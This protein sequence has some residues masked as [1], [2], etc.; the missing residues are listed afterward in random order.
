MPSDFGP[1]KL[2]LTKG[3]IRV[4]TRG[5]LTALSWKDRRDVSLLTNMDPS[6]EEGNFCGESKQAVKPQIVARYNWHMGYVDIS[7]RMANSYSMCRRT[8]KW[9]TKLFFHLLDLTVL[10][11]WILLSSCGAKCTHKDFSLLLVRNLIKEAGRSHYRPTP[12]M[13]GRPS[14]AAANMRLDSCHN[15]HWPAKHK[16]NIRCRVC[17]ERGQRKTA[18]YKCAKCDVCLCV[19]PCFSDYH[20][21]KM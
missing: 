10:N 8:F 4:R 7:D 14:A 18:I 17:S 15:Q 11:S 13:P 5:N 12:S 9:T 1:K 20:T 21:K 16:N 2:K 6:P 3:N 19:V